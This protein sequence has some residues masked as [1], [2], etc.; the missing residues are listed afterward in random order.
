MFLRTCQV[1][2]A[3]AALPAV[4]MAA[5]PPGAGE[6]MRDA[7][8]PA[9]APQLQAQVLPRALA[10]EQARQMAGGVTIHLQSLRITG[11]RTIPE[12]TLQALVADAI[13]K[14]LDFA[15][16]QALADRIGDHYR[17]QGYLLA[18]VFLP[19]QKIVQGAVQITVQEGQLGR[20][21]VDAAPVDPG[22]VQPWLYGLQTGE[23][24][25]ADTLE[26]DL[27][28]LGDLPGVTVQSV[29]R[30]GASGG[31]TDLDVQGR[32]ARGLHADLV[33]DN[34]GNR[35]TGE[36]RLT[37]HASLGS[38]REF[39]DSLDAVVTHGFSG[40]DYARL[41]WQ[42]PFGTTGD[43]V[44]VAGSLMGY[45]LG[46]EFSNLDARGHAIDLTLYGLSTLQ[47]SRAR[48]VQAQL[49]LD[50]KRF[51]DVANTAR[52]TK[53]AQV[54]TLGVSAQ[55]L[56][57]AGATSALSAGLTLGRLQLDDTS[58]ASDNLSLRT[59]GTYAK[60]TGQAEAGIPWGVAGLVSSVRLGG[61]FAAWRN[62]DSSEK[63]GLGGPQAVRAHASG[64]GSSDDALLF[65]TELRRA[66]G[67]AQVKL[68]FDAARGQ[69]SHRAPVDGSA[70]IQRATLA[71]AGLGLDMNLPAGVL[72]QTAVAWRTAGRASPDV[73]R[74]PRLWL[75]LAIKL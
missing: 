41:A 61:Q 27:L 20:I 8:P 64:E 74:N 36:W 12:A 15:Q 44:G 56:H 38:V 49:A 48:R 54:L 9:R 33:L 14:D 40:Y 51:D 13:G 19:A 52:S 23:P 1:A 7:P 4:A 29:L 28:L 73:D 46:K 34:H 71:G 26:R 11:M 75:L 45:E 22:V 6:L 31:Y 60:L 57:E 3:C 30:P 53:H 2:L 17:S 24:L 70:G 18:Q 42:Q 10:S 47:R 72:L 39:G 32:A 50:L 69:A 62:L 58:A 16:L 43:Q 65:G 63:M 67:D 5:A 35:Y 37:G 66:W 55:S 59:R 25:L 68:F 21:S